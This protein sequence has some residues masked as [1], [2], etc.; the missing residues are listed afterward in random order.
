MKRKNIWKATIIMALAI[1]LSACEGKAGPSSEE[2]APAMDESEVQAESKETVLEEEPDQPAGEE[3]EEAA[4]EIPELTYK[5]APLSV[6]P[7]PTEYGY[8]YSSYAIDIEE[9]GF[10]FFGDFSVYNKKTGER[11]GWDADYDWTGYP[12]KVCVDER[13]HYSYKY[14]SDDWPDYWETDRTTYVITV[15]HRGEVL[16]PEDIRVVAEMEYNGQAAG[17]YTFEVNAGA[18]DLHYNESRV[19]H[20]F[21]LLDFKGELFIPILNESDMGG[22]I[23]DY[24]NNRMSEG[25]TFH[26]LHVSGGDF[27]EKDLEGCFYPV[28]W[29]EEKKEFIP[30]KV[31]DGYELS[32]T[33]SREKND[34]RIFMGLVTDLDLEKGIPLELKT[35]MV[36]AYDDGEDQMVFA[37]D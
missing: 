9:V 18:G 22:G 14:M 36:P 21:N 10:T 20:G 13:P 6:E 25:F 19:V 8:T 28:Q 11:C 23:Y 3:E 37:W 2:P 35:Q 24:V 27:N 17:E 5:M 7:E 31:P 4:P 16:A 32:V 1:S 30:Y 12:G 26:F 15:E 33:V 34:L 29:D